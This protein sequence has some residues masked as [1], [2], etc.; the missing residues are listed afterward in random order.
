MQP[1]PPSTPRSQPWFSLLRPCIALLL[2]AWATL[3]QATSFT[4]GFED[5]TNSG[6]QQFTRT[7]GGTSFVFKFEVQG[8][9]GTFSESLGE[10]STKGVSLTSNG[11]GADD[12]RVTISRS[13]GGNF[14]FGSLWVDN[15]YSGAPVVLQGYLDGL[16]VGAPRNMPAGIWGTFFFGNITIDEI[17]ITSPDFDATI[18]DN[19]SGTALG[20]TVTDA[21]ISISGASGTGGAYKIGDTVTA[22]WNNTAGGDNNSVVTSVT[23]DF[24][25]F[26]G[27]AAVAATNSSGTWTATYTIVGGAIS[28]TNRN[29]SVTATNGAG[30]T[31][32]ADTSNA[33][34][35]SVSPSVTSTAPIGGAAA[36]ATSVDFTVTFS[37]FV[38]NI[39]TD[40]F[41][42]GFNGAVTG[43]IAS[44]S[45]S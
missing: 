1:T 10:S 22:T 15:S 9:G 33:T 38:S 40:D 32:V 2:F 41:A 24:S 20:P 29:V 42:L 3:A 27:G 16:E 45:A 5:F 4:D 14:Q 44:V 11:P 31:T 35:D 19:F 13:D 28:N 30:S 43:T 36:S 25:Q 34:V 39:S 18:L 6:S 37:E 8:Q 21:A 23:V 12:E 17:R 7:L 26:G